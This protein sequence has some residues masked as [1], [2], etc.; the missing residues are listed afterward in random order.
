[1]HVR[2]TPSCNPYASGPEGIYILSRA[3]P[4]VPVRKARSLPSFADQVP[5]PISTQ[6]Q[7][8]GSSYDAEKQSVVHEGVSSMLFYQRGG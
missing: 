5:V 6:C 7:A 8:G 4:P 3:P 1:M 2:G